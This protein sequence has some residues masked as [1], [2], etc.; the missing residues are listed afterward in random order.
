VE[1]N[2]TTQNP[3]LLAKGFTQGNKSV[4]TNNYMIEGCEISF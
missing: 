3:R 1:E 2:L 4:A